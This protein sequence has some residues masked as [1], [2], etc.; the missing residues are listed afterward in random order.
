MYVCRLRECYDC[1]DWGV[2]RS[3]S[4]LCLRHSGIV[5]KLESAITL[6]LDS[7]IISVCILWSNT[8]SSPFPRFLISLL[9]IILHGD[10]GLGSPVLGPECHVGDLF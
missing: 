8:C 10:M 2:E 5:G 9:L 3:F 6:L 4:V 1:V 7:M